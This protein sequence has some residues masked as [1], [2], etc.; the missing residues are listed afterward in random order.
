[1]GEVSGKAGSGERVDYGPQQFPDR[2]GFELWRFERALAKGLIPPAD[3][4]GRRWS[5]AVVEEV[6]GRAEEIRG[7]TGSLP[8][9][10][11]VRAAALLEER[12]GMPVAPE[13]LIELDRL[14]LVECVNSYKGWPLYDG[15][16]LEHF[17]DRAVLEK[18]KR[19]GRLLNRTAA[20]RRL[21]VRACDFDHLTKA[22]WLR[23]ATW[24]HSG[25]Q[26]RRDTPVV[27]LY[28]LG[29]LEVLLVHPAIDWE[30]VRATSKGRPSALARLSP[31]PDA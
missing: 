15:L 18:A 8:D 2:L 6:A 4:G 27:A 19:D 12:F 21:R 29:D 11:G 31:A 26:R 30:E 24:V 28:R 10:G 5:A 25:W 1:M 20:A 17:T 3:I 13:V 16:A 9:M 7:A 22:N 14:G 23:P